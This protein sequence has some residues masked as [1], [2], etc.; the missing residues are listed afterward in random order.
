MHFPD[1]N[2]GHCYWY[3]LPVRAVQ[4]TCGGIKNVVQAIWNQTRDFG[5][6]IALDYN[7]WREG[8]GFADH[9]DY[10]S[11]WKDLRETHA[12]RGLPV[13]MLTGAAA[14][15]LFS[16]CR[17][18]E[19]AIFGAV[20]YVFLRVMESLYKATPAKEA[21]EKYDYPILVGVLTIGGYSS[22]AFLQKVLKVPMSYKQGII[23]ATAA[24]LAHLGP[25]RKYT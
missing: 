13:A 9:E 20:N 2:D 6:D 23:L 22:M 21:K 3:Q 7:A 15:W 4:A 1:N 16:I 18:S 19:G 11:C 25:C 14:A 8:H 12:I 17:P 24:G 10:Q 5:N